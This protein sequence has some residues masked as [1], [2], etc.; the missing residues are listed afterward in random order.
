MEFCRN[1][2]IWLFVFKKNWALCHKPCA[3]KFEQWHVFTNV[4]DATFRKTLSCGQARF[5]LTI[6]APCFFVHNWT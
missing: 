1:Q 5:Q 4:S 2:S 6:F 3:E